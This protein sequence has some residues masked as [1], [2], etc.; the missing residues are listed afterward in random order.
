MKTIDFSI[1]DG[2]SE[3]SPKK[4]M[5]ANAGGSGQKKKGLLNSDTQ[6]FENQKA[7]RTRTDEVV[8]TKIAKNSRKQLRGSLRIIVDGR[9]LLTNLKNQS[10]STKSIEYHKLKKTLH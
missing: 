1:Q 10:E 4:M 3:T 8:E 9:D 2:S 6:R 7:D 5:S